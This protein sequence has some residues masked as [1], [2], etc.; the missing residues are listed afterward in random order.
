MLTD[1]FIIVHDGLKNLVQSLDSS[2]TP[3][4]SL[5]S[6]AESSPWSTPFYLAMVK[7]PVSCLKVISEDSSPSMRNSLVVFECLLRLADYGSKTKR[8]F[9]CPGIKICWF[10]RNSSRSESDRASKTSSWQMPPFLALRL[11]RRRLFFFSP[12]APSAP[13]GPKSLSSYEF[14]LLSSSSSLSLLSSFG[15]S[16]LLKAPISAAVF[17]LVWSMPD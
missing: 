6:S 7:P 3:L 2:Q 11:R 15:W 13:S 17:I 4:S 16:S 14:W 10:A 8:L 1:S 12:S 9:T 5:L